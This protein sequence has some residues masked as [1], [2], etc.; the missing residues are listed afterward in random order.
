[1]V[2]AAEKRG[3]VVLCRKDTSE[4]RDDPPIN[5]GGNAP[6]SVTTHIPVIPVDNPAG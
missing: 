4:L 3:V 6:W 2:Q 1:M 5:M